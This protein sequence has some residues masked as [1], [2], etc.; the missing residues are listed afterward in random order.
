MK[1]FCKERYESREEKRRLCCELIEIA[2]NHHQEEI[3]D[4]LQF[5]YDQ[6]LKMD[7][8]SDIELDKIVTL[9][10]KYKKILHGMLEGLNSIITGISVSLDPADP[11]T[12]V[13]LFS[14]LKSNVRQNSQD[15]GKVNTNEDIRKLIDRD[16]ADS[17]EKLAK[18]EDRLNHLQQYNEMLMKTIR[19]TDERLSTAQGLTAIERKKIFDEQEL[20]K[21]QQAVYEASTILF[22]REQEILMNRRNIISFIRQ[23]SNLFLFYRTVENRLQALFQSVLAAQGG[24]LQTQLSMKYTVAGFAAPFALSQALKFGKGTIDI[25]K[26]YRK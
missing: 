6:Q 23:N 19:E 25:L 22:R 7:I 2:K 12:F 15:I 13:N 20:N 8:P 26:T 4:I 17:N 18:I 9:D 10:A 14:K 16:V 5:H 1:E 11:K 24:Y 21:K 3:I